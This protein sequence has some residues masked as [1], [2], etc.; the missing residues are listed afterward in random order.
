[1]SVQIGMRVHANI[2][3]L[4]EKLAIVLEKNPTFLKGISEIQIL[5]KDY[6]NYDLAFYPIHYRVKV[7]LDRTFDVE[8]VDNIMV[9]LDAMNSVDKNIIEVDFRHGA[10]SCRTR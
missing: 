8:K 3:P 6:G 5:P 4:L 7:L 1:E 10:I 2:R 9:V